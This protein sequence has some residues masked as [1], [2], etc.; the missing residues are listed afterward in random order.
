MRCAKFAGWKRETPGF[1][2]ICRR[3]SKNGAVSCVSLCPRG[4]SD[5][6]QG[7]QI[8]ILEGA[9][10]ALARELEERLSSSLQ[11]ELRKP[12]FNEKIIQFAFSTPERLRS[13][14]HTTKWLHR[15][16]LKGLLPA[17]VLNRASKAEFYGHFPQTPG[18]HES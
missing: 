15:Q 13:R 6:G 17:L 9:F 5:A 4:F 8:Q 2:P 11:L 16:A 12:F 14:G 3:R 18:Q 1:P 7:I 10:D